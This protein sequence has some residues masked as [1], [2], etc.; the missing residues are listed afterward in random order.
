M[1]RFMQKIINIMKINGKNLSTSLNN[2]SNNNKVMVV[3]SYSVL[4]S[5]GLIY[6]LEQTKYL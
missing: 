4:L 6:G 1:C 2:L 3:T 5:S